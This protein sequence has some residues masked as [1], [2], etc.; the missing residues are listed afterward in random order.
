[1]EGFRVPQLGSTKGERRENSWLRSCF[2]YI[3][4]RISESALKMFGEGKGK[5]NGKGE[6]DYVCFALS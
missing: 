2:S 5:E 6:P 4:N 1:M 3:R